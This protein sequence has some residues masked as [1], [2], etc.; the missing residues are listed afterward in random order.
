[1]KNRTYIYATIACL[2]T[3]LFSSCITGKDKK[4]MQ[5]GHSLYK[6]VEFQQYKLR[7]NDEVSY[8]LMTSN[9]ETQRFYNVGGSGGASSV[10]FRIYENG[11][12]YI[13]TIGNIKIAGM[14]I[15]EA[16]SALKKT[17]TVLVPDAEIKLSLVNNN[18]YVQGDGGKGQFYLYKE[19]LN[20]FQAL[21]L[22][23]D[24][25]GSGD[26][27]HIKIIRKGADGMDYINTFDLREISIIESEYYYIQPND[28]IYIPTNSKAFFRVD[29]VSS[30][31]SMFVA[32]L[33]LF[34]MVLSL[35]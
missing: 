26:K 21:A 1:M 12:I 7:V 32:P 30:F 4:Y 25:S 29:S 5:E 20:I 17:F 14:T 33:S 23:G 11:S 34:V 24:I 28:V 13:P 10:S 2:I 3:C 27:Q 8:I 22:A 16:E 18:Y 15:R 35:F 19:N 31:V 9:A 6:P